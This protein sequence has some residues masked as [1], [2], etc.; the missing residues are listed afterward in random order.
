MKCGFVHINLKL[1]SS[2][3]KIFHYDTSQHMKDGLETVVNQVLKVGSG[4]L[5]ELG[6]AGGAPEEGCELQISENHVLYVGSI[7]QRKSRH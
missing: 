6:A 7:L 4:I 5:L 3:I 1:F 2:K